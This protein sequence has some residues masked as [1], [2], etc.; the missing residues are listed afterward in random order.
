MAAAGY[1]ALRERA[2]LLDDTDRVI[3]RVHGADA[4][5]HFGGLVTNH[6]E[7][8]EPGRALYAFML[9]PKGRPVAEVRVLARPAD[10]GEE[11][12][13]VDLP[14]A[15]AEEALDHL[16]RYLPPRLAAHE[17]L[18]SVG[19]VGVVGP[20]AARALG[21]AGFDDL[22]DG[23]LTARDVRGEGGRLS[24]VIVRREAIEG[25][26]FDVYL[27]SASRTATRER[28]DR[29]VR[30][31]GGRPVG[32]AAREAWRIERGIPVYGSEIGTDVLPQETGQEDRAV[33]H[34]K[35]CYTG[36][37]VVARIHHRG[38]VNRHLRGLR[39]DEA[40][41]PPDPGTELHAGGRSRATLTSVARS[42]RLGGI[43][44]GYVWRE[45]GPGDRLALDPEDEPVCTVVELPFD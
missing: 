42:P 19:R 44:L 39:F 40:V 27:P 33:D 4:R 38:K 20:R 5:E 22:P 9:T 21:A 10:D 26:G 45:L 18:G 25:P 2:A 23:E 30:E 32:G 8:L 29:G 1:D 24:A 3:L 37:E 17:V 34:E 41:D 13:W 7:A 12:L 36:Q 31:A 15:C 43:G 14:G 11:V 35:G 6:V 16:G 28:L